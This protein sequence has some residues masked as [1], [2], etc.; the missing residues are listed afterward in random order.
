MMSVNMKERPTILELTIVN[1]SLNRIDDYS[2]AFSFM[3]IKANV[4]S[5]R[6][7]IECRY[8]ACVHLL[9]AFRLRTYLKIAPCQNSRTEQMAHCNQVSLCSEGL[10]GSTIV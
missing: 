9:D 5:F 4:I 8:V 10:Q 6:T 1:R 7:S 3:S 2:L